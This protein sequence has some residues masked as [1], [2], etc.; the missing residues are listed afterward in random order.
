MS[1]NQIFQWFNNAELEHEKRTLLGVK[2]F[3]AKVMAMYE[4]KT[5]A[6]VRDAMVNDHDALNGPVYE[7]LEALYEKA[8]VA[9][10][11]VKTE[12]DEQGTN[13][14]QPPVIEKPKEIT[15][16]KVEKWPLGGF[17]LTFNE[18]SGGIIRDRESTCLT[19]ESVGEGSYGATLGL[20]VGDKVTNVMVANSTRS[21]SKDIGNMFLAIQYKG[22]ELPFRL[23]VLKTGAEANESNSA[24]GE[25]EIETPTGDES[26]G[27]HSSRSWSSSSNDEVEILH[28]KPKKNERSQRWG[29]SEE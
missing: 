22:M 1:H 5:M 29:E 4:C 14:E 15:I 28:A 23:T 17:G 19:I 27:S 18:I 13:T 9:C 24:G 3:A 26:S 20:R 2:F 6:E 25:G 10:G 11:G 12:E 8:L 16:I 7:N 21:E